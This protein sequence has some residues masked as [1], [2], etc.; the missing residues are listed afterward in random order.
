M[1]RSTSE[2]RRI[3]ARR[4]A[5][6]RGRGV[7][8]VA[9]AA[10]P[11][12]TVVA[13]P[14]AKGRAV[15]VSVNADGTGGGNGRSVSS[16][17]SANGRFVAFS[18]EASDLVGGDTNGTWDLFVRDLTNGTTTLV[19][20]S[21]DGQGT[22]NAMSVVPAISAGGRFVAF[23]SAASDLAPGDVNGQFDVFVRDVRN[24][25]T[26]LASAN[27][28]GGGGDGG[29]FDPAI[30]ADGRFLAFASDATDLVAGDTNALRDVFVRDA[31][32]RGT[33]LVSW[34]ATGTAPGNGR[35]AA[36]AVSANGRFV[37]FHSEASDLV[38]G[39]ANGTWDVFVRDL[40][41]GTT[42]LVSRSAAGAGT[43]NA[44]SVAP[45]I[46]ADGRLVAFGS[47]ASDLV[48]GD[49]NGQWDVFVVRVKR[50]GAILVSGD[51]GGGGTGTGGFPATSL[52]GNGR[53][54][55][56]EGWADLMPG[57]ASGTSEAFV[58]DTT[59]GRTIRARTDL[60]GSPGMSAAPRVC[61]NARRVSFASDATG[62]VPGG[63]TGVQVFVRR[64]R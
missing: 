1:G 32:S 11:L 16:S 24:G 46:S 30:S 63:T 58:R 21:A 62:L 4:S 23:C 51:A 5:P 35:S 44:M 3:G 36:P 19:S 61:A 25:T 26:T 40:K 59:R 60:A 64:L 17:L 8:I 42:T 47:F 43:S 15:L 48:V 52:S 18:S 53:F 54:V 31:K 50:G 12:A 41:Q 20:R 55:A 7:L 33:T 45:S 13:S 29:S 38:D 28:A 49:T 27:A 57:G 14:P 10:L 6:R 56:F 37:A 9:I 22:G 2:P 34:N 39:D